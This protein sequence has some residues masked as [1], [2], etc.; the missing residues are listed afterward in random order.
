MFI[1][2][3]QDTDIKLEK[4]LKF[5]QSFTGAFALSVA[6]FFRSGFNGRRAFFLYCAHLT[7]MSLT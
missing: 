4:Y 2:E 5:K 6:A 3:K 1:F 7:E